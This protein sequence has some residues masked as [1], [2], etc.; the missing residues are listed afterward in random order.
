[1]EALLAINNAAVPNVNELDLQALSHLRQ[2][3]TYCRVALSGDELA[4]LLIALRPDADYDS[5]NFVWFRE[6]YE[7][8]VYIDRVV[9]A[10]PFRGL[11]IGRVFYA[12]IQSHAEQIA[13]MLTC[14]V[15]LEPRNNTSLLFH[16]TKGFNEVGQQV[17]ENGK[18]RVCLLAKELP[19]YAFVKEQYSA[20]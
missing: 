17:T 13:P 1:M 8:F 14:E 19:S 12:D 2:Q 16:G 10:K 15:N 7:D 6:H 4:G 9:V 18:K 3:A 5:E 11:G 20:A